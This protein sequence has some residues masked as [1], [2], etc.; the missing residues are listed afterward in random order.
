M[1]PPTTGG[2]SSR[3]SQLPLRRVWTAT[4]LVIWVLGLAGLILLLVHTP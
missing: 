3:L 4:L 2:P 1:T